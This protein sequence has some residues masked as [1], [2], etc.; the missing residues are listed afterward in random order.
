MAAAIGTALTQTCVALVK[1]HFCVRSD[2]P[3]QVRQ[4]ILNQVLS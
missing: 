4:T 1:C 3:L 2:G